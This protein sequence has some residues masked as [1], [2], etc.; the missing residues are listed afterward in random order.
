MDVFHCGQKNDHF[1]MCP[2]TALFLQVQVSIADSAAFLLK[3]IA[4]SVKRADALHL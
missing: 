4:L 1:E 3:Y 2:T